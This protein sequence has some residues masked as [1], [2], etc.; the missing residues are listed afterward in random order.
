MDNFDAL[1]S[2]LRAGLFNNKSSSV[3]WSSGMILA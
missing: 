2:K 3:W 1:M